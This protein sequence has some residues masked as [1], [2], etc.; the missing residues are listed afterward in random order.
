MIVFHNVETSGRV[1]IQ[2]VK[3]YCKNCEYGLTVLTY[4][5][6]HIHEIRLHI[7]HDTGDKMRNPGVNTITFKENEKPVIIDKSTTHINK[8]KIQFPPLLH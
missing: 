1:Q 2:Y 5:A 4:S 3:L 6:F 7:A 8:H